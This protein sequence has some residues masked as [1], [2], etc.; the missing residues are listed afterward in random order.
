[1]KKLFFLK[2]FTKSYSKNNKKSNN[3]TS[4]HPALQFFA[5]VNSVQGVVSAFS[6]FFD[7]VEI[8]SIDDAE[9]NSLN[10][11]DTPILGPEIIIWVEKS[12]C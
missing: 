5:F 8:I 11:N 9:E 6:V 1:M 10:E 4:S 7:S 12:R 3:I 2:K